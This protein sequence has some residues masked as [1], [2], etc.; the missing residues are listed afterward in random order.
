MVVNMMKNNESF[1]QLTLP[2]LISIVPS[3]LCYLADALLEITKNVGLRILIVAISYI[4]SALIVTKAY[5]YI[6]EK[7]TRKMYDKYVGRWI[8]YIPDFSR[9]I[10]VCSIKYEGENQFTFAGKNYDRYRRRAVA[11][12]ATMFIK[13]APDKLYYITSAHPVGRLTKGIEGFGRICIRDNGVS[14]EFEGD[15][16]F[17]DVSSANRESG[18]KA[19]QEYKIIKYDNSLY[20][21]INGKKPEKSIVEMRDDEIYQNIKG[22]IEIIFK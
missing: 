13:D 6:R 5:S 11:F 1:Q 17:F 22:K 15:G 18:E 20:E 12:S 4:V 2:L 8:Q 21:R 9:E 10:A 14:G 19:L 7:N 16:F 3:A